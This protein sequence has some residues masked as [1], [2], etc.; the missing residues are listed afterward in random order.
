MKMGTLAAKVCTSA[1]FPA[2]KLRRWSPSGDFG[3]RENGGM[4][5]YRSYRL[6]GREWVLTALLSFLI[7][8]L[9]SWLFYRSLI[10]LVL[11]LPFVLMA[12]RTVGR[13]QGERRGRRLLLQFRD[14][15]R[16]LA[17]AMS[18]GYSAENA[19]V[20][21]Q[22]ELVRMYGAEE[23][24]SREFSVLIHRQQLGWTVEAAFQ[25]LAERSGLE[26]VEVLAQV[27]AIARQS[28]GPLPEILRQTLR[29]WEDKIQ[30][31]EEIMT[32]LTSQRLEFWIMCLLPPL[33]LAYVGMGGFLDP[34]YE[35]LI[36]RTVMTVG[37]LV[38]VLAVWLGQKILRVEVG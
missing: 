13:I 36:G 32:T 23:M 22:K 8:T 10:L 25:E 31:R 3:T 5:D 7:L 28:G 20:Q 1:R 27:F 14:G 30:L 18:A 16:A 24:L 4:P 33:M 37:I 34:L 38:Y 29:T 17:A 9:F 2:R 6:S 26:D 12:G 15:M 21:A 11:F 35:G 19:F